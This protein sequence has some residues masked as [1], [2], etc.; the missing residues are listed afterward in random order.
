M[1]K[2]TNIEQ[3]KLLAWQKYA[4]KYVVRPH[5]KSLFDDGFTAG[6]EYQQAK[7]DKLIAYIK[8]EVTRSEI[9]G[10]LE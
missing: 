10:L 3:A 1:H 5:H 9:E 2:L 7:L 6:L 4:S 8:G